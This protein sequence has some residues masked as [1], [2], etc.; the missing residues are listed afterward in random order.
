MLVSLSEDH[1]P[2]E[3]RDADRSVTAQAAVTTG[4]ERYGHE[5][6]LK[7]CRSRLM[8]DD[9]DRSSEVGVEVDATMKDGLCRPPLSRSTRQGS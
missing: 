6:L 1:I 8:S 9:H 2:T 5:I 4:D 3:S 7:D